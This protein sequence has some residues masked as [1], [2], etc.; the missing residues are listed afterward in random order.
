M[1]TF[2]CLLSGSR[3]I[4]VCTGTLNLRWAVTASS[5]DAVCV[6]LNCGNLVHVVA[7]CMEI[8]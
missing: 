1:L 8:L 4:S 3:Q 7:R 6:D 2:L 5:I